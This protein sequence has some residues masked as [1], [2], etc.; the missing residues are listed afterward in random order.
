MR[1]HSATASI[2]SSGAHR[3]PRRRQTRFGFSEVIDPGVSLSE[4]R[5]GR[6]DPARQPAVADELNNSALA[7]AR[8][9]INSFCFFGR[10]FTAR[11]STR[12][13]RFPT[14]RLA[15]DSNFCSAKRSKSEDEATLARE[16]DPDSVCNAPAKLIDR[17]PH[18]WR[19]AAAAIVRR[20]R[21]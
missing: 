5:F 19:I 8:G 21:L 3:E 11:G 9:F 14:R 20:I 2:V 13:G 17:G 16:N 4:R 12:F 18:S 7:T 15:I 1:V 10:R 6:H